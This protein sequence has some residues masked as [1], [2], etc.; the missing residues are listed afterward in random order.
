M[1]N[2]GPIYLTLT[3]LF[4]STY[5]V[6][7]K[8][9][10]G[11]ID[12]IQVNFIRFLFGGLILL[13]LAIRDIRRNNIKLLLKDYIFLLALGMLSVGISMNLLQNGI[14][15]TRANLAAVIFSSNPLFVA[16]ISALLMRES[17]PPVKM[18]GL[19]IGFIGVAFT[20][21]GEGSINSTF[22]NGILFLVLAALIFGLY[23][24]VGKKIATRIGSLAMNSLCF[25]FGSLSLIPVLLIK[26]IPLFSFDPVIWPQIIYLTVFVTGLAYY[27]YFLGL[28]MVDTSLGSM[29]F[30]VKPLLASFLA[31]VVLGEK[32]SLNLIFG[33][34]LV[35]VSIYVVQRVVNKQSG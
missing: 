4:F 18:L 27:S 22:Y 30:F 5:E 19:L 31:A 14:N 25:I 1:R 15:L 3:I 2:K 32:L 33:T 21:A 26:D 28:S 23:T 10:V 29:V 13:P 17:L 12:P 6:V 20:F 8:T 16:L 9:V 35:L 24:V 11:Y 7:S 34:L